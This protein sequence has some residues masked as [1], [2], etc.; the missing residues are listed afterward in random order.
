MPSSLFLPTG[1]H[2]GRITEDFTHEDIHNNKVWRAGAFGIPGANS[3]FSVL[4]VTP[5]AV[6]DTIH[7]NLRIETNGPGIARFYQGPNASGG[8]SITPSNANLSFTGSVHSV[9]TSNPTMTASVGSQIGITVIGSTGFKAAAGG[10]TKSELWM[11]KPEERY[12]LQFTA[13]A[14][15]TRTVLK[16]IWSE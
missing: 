3:T 7:L 2:G 5:A 8:S 15:S 1:S 6:V 11:L 16:F 12:V 13:D 14:A 10:E 9:L 4:M